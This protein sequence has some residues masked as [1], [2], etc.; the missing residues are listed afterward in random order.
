YTSVN[1]GEDVIAV[2]DFVFPAI[3]VHFGAAILADE[4]AVT[5]LD[6]NGNDLAVVVL[7][8]RTDSDDNSLGGLFPGG[9]RYDD[10]ASLDF[11]FLG[12]LNQHVVCERFYLRF[13]K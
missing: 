3:Q 2:E 7:L 1:Y 13:H 5:L 11:L 9:I 8:P 6:F 10:A 4:H 12:W